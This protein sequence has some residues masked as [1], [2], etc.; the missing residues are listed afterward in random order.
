M[1]TPPPASS[2]T[3]ARDDDRARTRERTM[4]KQNSPLVHPLAAR[5]SP[6]R[7]ARR[8][9]TPEPPR[10]TDAARADPSSAVARSSAALATRL[11]A[12]RRARFRDIYSSRRDRRS[13]LVRA[14]RLKETERAPIAGTTPRAGVRWWTGFGFL[15]TC[16]LFTYV[17]DGSN[18]QLGRN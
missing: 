18:G 7:A 1:A 11:D 8:I 3:R 9:K 13:H 2:T 15:M 10:V 17:K 12:R 4:T 16:F 14:A 6:S 5:V